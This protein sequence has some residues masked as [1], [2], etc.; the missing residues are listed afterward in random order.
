MLN[1]NVMGGSIKESECKDRVSIGNEMAEMWLQGFLE[2]K[3]VC[4]L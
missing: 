2:S 4:L 1:D 3:G